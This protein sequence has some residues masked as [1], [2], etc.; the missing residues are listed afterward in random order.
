MLTK[1]HPS[2]REN[3]F[4]CKHNDKFEIIIQVDEIKLKHISGLSV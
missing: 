3:I 4:M 2:Q 1:C